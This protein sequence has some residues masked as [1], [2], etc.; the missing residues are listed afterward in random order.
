MD[1][2]NK[3]IGLPFAEKGRDL[4]GLDCWGLVQLVYQAERDII[5]PGYEWCY[6]TTNDRERLGD[7]ISLERQ[8]R[9]I[10]VD[11]PQPFDAVLLSMRGVPMHVGLVTRAGSMIHCA[12]GVGAVHERYDGM[13]WQSKVKGFFRYE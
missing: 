5:L 4:S 8:A 12:H 1:W 11:Q 2:W 3:Y 9:W 10:Q 7:A 13:R 6:Q